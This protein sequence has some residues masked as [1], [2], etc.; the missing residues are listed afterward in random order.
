MKIKVKPKPYFWDK[1]TVIKFA[2]FPTRIENTI[3]WLEM[4]ACTYRYTKDSFWGYYYWEVFENK[5]LN[6]QD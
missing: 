1:K 5:L 4:Y 2:W 3:I 6:K